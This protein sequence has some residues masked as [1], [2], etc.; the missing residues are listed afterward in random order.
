MPAQVSPRQ[1]GG[2]GLQTMISIHIFCT[3]EPPSEPPL[4]RG[5]NVSDDSQSSGELNHL[6][7]SRKLRYLE[8]R[9]H[10]EILMYLFVYFADIIA[11]EREIVSADFVVK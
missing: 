7:L 9:I 1:L 8:C 2:F 11:T 10:T 4:F 5:I 3:S 6:H